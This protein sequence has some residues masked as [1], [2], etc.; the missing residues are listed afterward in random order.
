MTKHQNLWCIYAA[1]DEAIPLQDT[2]Y[3]KSSYRRTSI[4]MTNANIS[5]VEIQTCYRD[6]VS[7]IFEEKSIL[8]VPRK[9]RQTQHVPTNPYSL[10][11]VIISCAV[12]DELI[13]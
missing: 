5:I 2:P 3:Y 8:S 11:R 12:I 1:Q 10:A 9:L 7:A 4:I 13:D 6:S